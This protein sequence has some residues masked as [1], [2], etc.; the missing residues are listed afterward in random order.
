LKRSNNSEKLENPEFIFTTT[1]ENDIIPT[2]FGEDNEGIVSKYFETPT[3][4]NH[5][6]SRQLSI[7]KTIS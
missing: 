6:N 1:N 3:D 4:D 5:T 7:F 2:E